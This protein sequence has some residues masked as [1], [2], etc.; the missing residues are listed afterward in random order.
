MFIVFLF[1]LA[2]QYYRHYHSYFQGNDIQNEIKRL[3]FQDYLNSKYIPIKNWSEE[4][5]R[6]VSQEDIQLTDI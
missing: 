5:N 2:I 4:L 3:N 6:N 1:I